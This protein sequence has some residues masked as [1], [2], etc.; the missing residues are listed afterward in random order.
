MESFSV[1]ILKERRR[2]KKQCR[3]EVSNNFSALSDLH[4]ETDKTV[5]GKPFLD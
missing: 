5:V 3:V 1:N 2:D 4:A